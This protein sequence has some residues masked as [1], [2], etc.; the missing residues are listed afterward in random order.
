MYAEDLA[1]T[2]AGSMIAALVSVSPYETCFA[3]PVDHDLLYGFYSASFPSSSEI[4]DVILM[5]G[6]E[7]LYLF[8]SAS[9]GRLSDDELI[10]EYGRISLGIITLTDFLFLPWIYSS[11]QFLPSRQFL[12][13]FSSSDVDLNLDL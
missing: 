5:F 6:H 10:Y 4:P 1:Q 3:N 11:F 9:R 7:T 12:A 2:G 13:C 8:I